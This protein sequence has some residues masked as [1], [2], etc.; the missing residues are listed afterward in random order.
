MVKGPPMNSCG[1]SLPSLACSA[2]QGGHGPGTFENI[3]DN[4][5]QVSWCMWWTDA[6]YGC[7]LPSLACSETHSQQGSNAC[8]TE[9]SSRMNPWIYTQLK[10]NKLY[11]CG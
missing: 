10:W 6:R 3:G 5:C 9:S 4:K 2:Q 1:C 11:G 7:S 8:H